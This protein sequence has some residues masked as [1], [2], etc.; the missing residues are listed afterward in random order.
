[1]LKTKLLQ[2]TLYVDNDVYIRDSPNLQEI[3][4]ILTTK[5]VNQKFSKFKMLIKYYNITLQ[6]I[7]YQYLD[8]N[9]LKTRL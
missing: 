3:I 7:E 5:M 4:E 2:V 6:Q 9:K 1:M 8:L